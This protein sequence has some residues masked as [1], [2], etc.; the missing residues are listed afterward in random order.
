MT[1]IL[2]W[3]ELTAG[4]RQVKEVL[5]GTWEPPAA[6]RILCRRGDSYHRSDEHLSV[7]V[8]WHRLDPND[9]VEPA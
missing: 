1:E 3:I 6:V 9:Y 2:A 7:S 8:E 5:A 4:L